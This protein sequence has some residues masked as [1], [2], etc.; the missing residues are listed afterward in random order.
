MTPLAMNM[1]TTKLMPLRSPSS[2]GPS[3]AT[4]DQKRAGHLR[5]AADISISRVASAILAFIGVR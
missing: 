1:A 4:L 5:C 3:I 2:I